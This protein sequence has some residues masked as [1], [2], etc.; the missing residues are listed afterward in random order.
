MSVEFRPKGEKRPGGPVHEALEVKR[1]A[2]W[3]TAAKRGGILD[4]G[5]GFDGRVQM[6][7][8][9]RVMVRAESYALFGRPWGSGWVIETK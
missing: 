6:M 3:K 1:R 7:M 4:G 9:K 8:I 5:R 2:E